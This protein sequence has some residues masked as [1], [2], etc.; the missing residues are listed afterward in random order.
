MMETAVK[1]AWS[2]ATQYTP[3]FHITLEAERGAKGPDDQELGAWLQQ[4]LIHN[5]TSEDAGMYAAWLARELEASYPTTAFTCRVT[6]RV[7]YTDKHARGVLI[8]RRPA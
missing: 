1:E 7:A 5:H 8:R 4:T 3:M 6:Y 2:I